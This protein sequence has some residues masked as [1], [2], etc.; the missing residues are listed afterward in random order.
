MLATVI[1]F[2]YKNCIDCAT[3]TTMAP[4]LA[5]SQLVM[6]RDMIDSRSV[7]GHTVCK[8]RIE[9]HCRKSP[10]RMWIYGIQKFLD[11]LKENLP[12]TLDYIRSFIYFAYSVITLLLETAPESNETWIEISTET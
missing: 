7:L 8:F 6:I 10:A 12:S 1:Y 9:A 2:L 5:P 11:L 4:R 3:K